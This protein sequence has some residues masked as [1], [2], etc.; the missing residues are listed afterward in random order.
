MKKKEQEFV[1]YLVGP[2]EDTS[3]N[4]LGWRVEY[5]NRLK[6]Y[7]VRCIIP[8]FEEAELIPDVEKFNQLKKTNYPE[9]KEVMRK[10]AVKDIGFVKEAD[11]LIVRW[12]GES[13]SGSVAEVHEAFFNLDTPAYLVTSLPFHKVPGWFGCCMDEEFHTLDELIEH[14]W[15]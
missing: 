15:G 6:K 11:F 2:M 8:N 4:G 1:T 14:L 13:M 5:R 7:N 9:F 3:D 12:E 10:I